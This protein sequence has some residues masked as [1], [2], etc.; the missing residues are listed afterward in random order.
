MGCIHIY[1]VGSKTLLVI[2]VMRRRQQLV[3]LVQY[4]SIKEEL[5]RDNCDSFGGVK[6]DVIDL[7]DVQKSSSRE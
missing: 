4:L 3:M 7:S 1:Q 5:G 2:M 6:D